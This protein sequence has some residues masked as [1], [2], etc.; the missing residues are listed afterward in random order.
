[1]AVAN[2][3]GIAA[4]SRGIAANSR[5]VSDQPKLE[6]LTHEQSLVD[7]FLTKCT[8]MLHKCH[9]IGDNYHHMAVYYG[10]MK[11]R[12]QLAAS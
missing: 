1:M 12:N 8:R 11:E 6:P 2:S 7:N 4:N 3:R 9:E 5:C 10:G